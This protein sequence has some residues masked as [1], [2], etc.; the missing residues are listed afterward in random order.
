MADILV[1]LEVN[2]LAA[3]DH[4]GEVEMTKRTVK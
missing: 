3:R 2:I 4:V 1:N